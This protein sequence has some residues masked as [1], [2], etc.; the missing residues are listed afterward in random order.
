MLFSFNSSWSWLWLLLFK[1]CAACVVMGYVSLWQTDHICRTVHLKL[2]PALLWCR[3]RDGPH[4]VSVSRETL[5]TEEGMISHPAGSLAPES[6]NKAWSESLSVTLIGLMA[7]REGWS[8]HDA[9][10]QR[11]LHCFDHNHSVLHWPWQPSARY[12]CVTTRGMLE[13][14]MF[15]PSVPS[16][17]SHLSYFHLVPQSGCIQTP[18]RVA[19]RVSTR[20]LSWARLRTP[21]RLQT[22]AT[23]KVKA[24]YQLL[25]LHSSA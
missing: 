19:G 4:V 11:T 20:G 15:E 12:C 8:F 5:D 7:M 13:T 9:S 14:R 10:K 24:I 17:T 2:S 25:P 22:V 23:D 3:G 1:C 21:R 6:V 16:P 18:V